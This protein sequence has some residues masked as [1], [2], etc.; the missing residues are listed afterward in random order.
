MRL[1]AVI[2][3]WEG[4]A[5]KARAI[6]QA[7]SGAV[8][9]LT[10]I[11]SNRAEQPETGPGT[12]VQV[13]QSWYFGRKFRTALEHVSED[14]VM[15]QIQADAQCDD[16]P[17]LAAGCAQCFAGHPRIGLWTPDVNWSPWHAEVVGEGMLAD[18]NLL[19]V[20][21]T[22]GIVWA[23]HPALYPA[24]SALDYER[25]NLG[26]GID[27]VAM[28]EAQNQNRIAVRDLSYP[29]HHPHSRGYPNA[30]AAQHMKNFLGQ[31]PP[32][33]QRSIR[34]AHDAL[35]ARKRAFAGH[36][37]AATPAAPPTTE[38]SLMPWPFFRAPFDA[39]LSEAFVIAGHVY[40]KA[41]GT[42]IE[43]AMAV[44]CG[45]VQTPLA[46]LADGPPRDHVTTGFPLHAADTRTSFQQLN[47]LEEWQ[48]DGWPTLRVIPGAGG[49]RQSIAL[50]GDMT[51]PPGDSP[52]VFAANL[53]VHRGKGDL[54]VRLSDTQGTPVHE[55]RHRFETAYWGGTHSARY[56]HVQTLLPPSD[57]PLRLSLHIETD[58]S[59]E[60]TPDQPA[61]FFVARPRL[62][63]GD[64]LLAPAV[65]QARKP[66]GDA[67]W[68][69]AR[70]TPGPDARAVTLMAGKKRLGLLS[71]PEAT[72]TL[73]KD[74]GPL[75]ELHADRAVSVSVW[76]G[77]APCCVMALE[78]G[79]NILHLPAHDFAGAPALLELREP[80]GTLVLWQTWTLPPDTT[81][82][83]E[84]ATPP[85]DLLA[86]STAR[87]A[88]LRRHLADPADVTLLPQ[89]ETALSALE[90][91]PDVSVRAP[92]RFAAVPAPQVSVLVT[93]DAGLPVTYTCLAALLL[94]WN[95]ASFEV[96]VVTDRDGPQLEA[97]VGGIT[98]QHS[99]AGQTTA[100]NSAAA[101]ARGAY[102]TLLDSTT[103][104]TTGWLD[105]L[106]DSFGRFG[107]GQTDRIG[108]AGAQ[109]LGP[110]GRIASAGGQVTQAQGLVARGAGEAPDDPRYSYARAVDYLPRG[111]LMLPKPLWTRLGGLQ[112]DPVL[113][114]C[115]Q[116]DLALRAR[117]A[118]HAAWYIPAARIYGSAQQR[119]AAAPAQLAQAAAAAQDRPRA[120]RILVIADAVPDGLAGL[121][122][123][124]Y[125]VTLPPGAQPLPRA[126]IR[127]LRDAGIEVITPPFHADLDSV[128]EARGPEFDGYYIIGSALA[129]R[130]V[131]GLRSRNP[132]AQ[133]VLCAPD[134][135][136][137]AD[138]QT[139]GL[140]R[141]VDV[142][143]S[144]D[145]AALRARD[146]TLTVLPADTPLPDAFAAAG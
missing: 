135:T 115:P 105:A 90:A 13:P 88:A 80:S 67:R 14:E 8:D 123:A 114:P 139:I 96:I 10:V 76:L 28:L 113:A 57:R 27:W 45:G 98:V 66:R 112:T 128:L 65:T 60:A 142:V 29:V 116:A 39:R 92:L 22:D 82:P 21:Q 109:M 15:L 53:A 38:T 31:L 93:A 104:V 78:A 62:R 127:A 118:G 72:L 145:P 77:G 46:P 47:G 42:G 106:L 23:L 17:A 84:A 134:I 89:L 59:P 48:V 107:E 79:E 91:G 141:S 11:Y 75:L 74:H 124:G 100:L 73:T 110:D 32:C 5:D 120:G 146:A 40:V 58:P 101:Q 136:A 51:I 94:A 54:V 69:S 137:Q 64:G 122:A 37:K 55:A 138:A 26:W 85:R 140:L 86:R 63:A 132:L 95:R 126:D 119:P 20:A 2:I 16:W 56:K 133:L 97:L 49:A 52:Q 3:S 43:A 4:H 1:H 41:A 68:Y 87:M 130:V 103:E 50:S 33:A 111:A 121:R 18:T 24:L 34:T 83:D 61:V 125:R 108:L 70:I 117:A 71:L 144:P 102:I 35:E 99:D 12:W 44:E 9:G 36:S 7:L 131:P 6:A 30:E 25:N 19:Q 81:A 129:R 143:L